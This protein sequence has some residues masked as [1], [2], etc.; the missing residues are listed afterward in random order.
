[1][2]RI[3]KSLLLRRGIY[4]GHV[5]NRDSLNDFFKKIKPVQT[6]HNLIRLG[7]A[8]DGGYLVPDDLN[9]I[10]YCFSPGVSAVADFELDLTKR[11]I[12]CFL[13]DY[14]VDGPPIKNSL[15]D[16]EKNTWVWLRMMY[17]QRLKAGLGERR[18][19]ILI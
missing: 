12:K 3:F 18:K 19:I 2:K 16:F 11:N 5:T 8:G 9:G 15:F 10:E 4:V 13:A 1:M 14:S 17:L 7:G 6:N